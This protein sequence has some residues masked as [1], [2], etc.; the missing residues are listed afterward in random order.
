MS[1][2]SGPT[3]K[4]HLEEEFSFYSFKC[5]TSADNLTT[6]VVLDKRERNR[7]A[8]LRCQISTVQLGPRGGQ[9]DEDIA[10]S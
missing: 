5:G 4:G 7:K 3:E 1:T 9:S 2:G 10:Y 8:F 6:K